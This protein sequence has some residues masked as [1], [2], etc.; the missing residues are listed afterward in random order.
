ME[1]WHAKIA[2][3]QQMNE[4]L[5]M[6][7]Q[8][9]E[10]KCKQKGSGLTLVEIAKPRSLE[11]PLQNNARA[12]PLG[13][14]ADGKTAFIARRFERSGSATGRVN[15]ANGTGVS[16][17]CVGPSSSQDKAAGGDPYR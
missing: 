14:D 15:M 1:K 17:R 16:V 11:V 7:E 2:R 10:Q 3:K 6:R 13:L 12:L 9:R 5:D 8:A 4:H